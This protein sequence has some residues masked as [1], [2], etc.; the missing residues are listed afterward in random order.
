MNEA[1][2]NITLPEIR[3]EK[4]WFSP[5]L[6]REMPTCRWGTKGTPLLLFP[7]AGGDYLE[8][9]RMLMLK[10]LKPL[11]E[12][13]RLQVICIGSIS[14]ES[15]LD[16]NAKPWHKSWL[17]ARFDQYLVEELLPW[18]TNQTGQKLVAAG[19]S[20]GAYN[21]L[22]ASTKHPQFFQKAICMSGTYKFERWMDGHF[23]QN[24]YFNM[25]LHFL[26]S[27]GDGP[28]LAAIREVFFLLASGSGRAEAPWE[29]EW[30]AGIFRA[31]GVRHHTE[32]WGS[33]VHHDWPTWRTM[34]PLF[35]DRLL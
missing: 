1:W 19:A 24:Y 12:A 13:G 5:A 14:G 15:W 34:L 2:R 23:D 3:S 11:I 22:N 16:A 30:I 29:S 4:A 25:P 26:P 32:I 21:A 20:L 7:T 17:Q 8:N 27:L 10:V 31:K 9:E 35:L 33:D 28:Q 6:Q 18:A